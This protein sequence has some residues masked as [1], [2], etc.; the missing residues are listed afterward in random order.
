MI[1]FIW[2][3]VFVLIPLPFLVRFMPA[4]KQVGG[5]LKVPFYQDIASM[6]EG[7]ALKTSNYDKRFFYFYLIWLLLVIATARPQWLGEPV[8]LPV[9]GRDLMLAIDISGSMELPDLKLDD[10]PVTRLQVIKAVAGDFI[11]RRIGDRLGLILFGKRAYIQT[12]LTFDRTTVHTMLNEA[13]IGLAG[14]ET[15]I[16][17]AIGLAVKR[18][19]EKSVS[20][21]LLILLTDGANTAGEVDPKQAAELAASEGLKIHTVGIGADSMEVG[22]VSGSAS[23]NPFALFGNRVINPS[24]DLDEETLKYIANITGGKYF[25]ARDTQGLEEIYRQLDKLEPTIKD[26]KTY[27]PV[28]E[29]YYLFLS[30]SLFL[31][32]SYLI[33]YIFLQSSVSAKQGQTHQKMSA[34]LLSSLIAIIYSVRGGNRR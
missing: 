8:T 20:D 23:I 32:V 21:R 2:P 4:R 7:G 12:P 31:S 9:T 10:E 11:Q 15:A 27:R 19:R 5:I 22:N 24:Q 33:F 29:L 13:E 25:R 17:D 30:A 14:K 34:A 3:W 1:Q 26:E 6:G 28:K 16:G 18:L